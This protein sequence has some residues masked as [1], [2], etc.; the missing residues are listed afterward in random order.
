MTLP[1][2]SGWIFDPMD[3]GLPSF[4][5]VAL[6]RERGLSQGQVGTAIGV[7]L[8]GMFAGAASVIRIDGRKAPRARP[9]SASC[10]VLR[11]RGHGRLRYV[12]HRSAHYRG[13]RLVFGR[14]DEGADPGRDLRA[15]GRARYRPGLEPSAKNLYA[16]VMSAL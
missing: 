11:G 3:V 7:G 10:S 5:L 8:F 1:S 2:G 9:W 6:E 16:R 4:V 12:R 15:N 14:R 13:E